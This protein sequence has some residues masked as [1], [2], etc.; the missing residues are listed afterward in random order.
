MNR[1]N[2]EEENAF[3]LDDD[4]DIFAML[5]QAAQQGSVA[6]ENLDDDESDPFA[7][8]T[9]PTQIV[10]EEQTSGFQAAPQNID[11]FERMLQEGVP[12]DATPAQH[13]APESLAPEEQPAF[14]SVPPPVAVQPPQP[15]V[16][17]VAPEPIFEALSENSPTASQPLE[18]EAVRQRPAMVVPV[19][20]EATSAHGAAISLTSEE[21][22]L[23]VAK[24]V[25]AAV[26]IY[27][28]L[29]KEMQ[30]IVAQLIS[31]DANASTAEETVAIKAVHADELIFSTMASL[32]EAK[33]KEAVDRAFYILELSTDVRENLGSL[34]EAFAD[35][36]TVL[37]GDIDSLP[38]ARSLVQAIEK[39]SPSAIQYV[40][41]TEQVLRAAKQR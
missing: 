32:K 34:V 7:S 8:L 5:D 36:S 29:S 37:E 28:S 4:T 35:E 1:P 40:V 11:E 23:R 24:A 9:G 22:F 33:E 39:L 13:Q 6:T 20:P 25:I 14:V 17:P 38:Y 41:A 31:Q 21:E 12:I 27:R 19:V 16:T 10:P 26:D 30:S 2:D 15:V 18:T 3:A